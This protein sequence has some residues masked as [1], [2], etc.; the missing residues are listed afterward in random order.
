[1]IRISLCAS[2]EIED[3]MSFIDVHWQK[4]HILATNRVLMDWQH[5]TADSAYDYLIAREGEK[6]LGVLG[7][8]ATRRFDLALSGE[9]V[10][11]LALWKVAEDVRVAGL[12]LRMLN[13][14]GKL[15]PHV[16]IAVNGI[17]P[18]HPPL[19]KALRYQV[20]ELQQYF[21]TS[22]EHRQTLITAPSGYSWPVPKGS[23]DAWEEL[24]EEA[25]RSLEPLSL[26]VPSLARKTP[27][28]FLNRFLRHPIYRYRVFLLTGSGGQRALIAA[29]VAGHNG[30]R[31]VRLVDFAGDPGCLRESGG[32]L[33]RLLAESDAEYAD[34]WAYGMSDVWIR[35]TGMVP[36]DP[37]MPL[38]VPNYFEPFVA[39]TGRILCAAKSFGAAASPFMIFRADGDQDRPNCINRGTT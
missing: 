10:I 36:V 28:Y 15:E 9:N 11:W 13:A 31:V 22:P 21:V 20:G 19:Y 35:P 7:F 38:V 6:V 12:G 8:I 24:S 27:V 33:A 4:G 26:F 25:L 17:N 1:M 18:A 14:L 32:G 30:A 39:R 37:S 2:D 23:G 3:V 16:A 29:R 34:F 5:G